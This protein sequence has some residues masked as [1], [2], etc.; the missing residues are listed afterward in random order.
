MRRTVGRPHQT[1]IIDGGAPRNAARATVAVSSRPG[2]PTVT[3]VLVVEDDPA[4]R[5]GLVDARSASNQSRW[6]DVRERLATAFQQAK[7]TEGVSDS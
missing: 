2:D 3:D 6:R 1:R 7:Q 5:R 4:I